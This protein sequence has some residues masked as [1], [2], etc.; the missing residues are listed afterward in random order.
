MQFCQWKPDKSD[1]CK[2]R[3]KT[4]TNDDISQQ[5]TYYRCLFAQLKLSSKS[6][7]RHFHLHDTDCPLHTQNRLHTYE[8]TFC[9]KSCLPAE[10]SPPFGHHRQKEGL[11][12]LIFSRRATNISKELFMKPYLFAEKRRE[13]EGLMGPEYSVRVSEQHQTPTDFCSKD[14]LS[15]GSIRIRLL[16]VFSLEESKSSAAAATTGTKTTT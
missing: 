14:F 16:C 9:W 8:G 2:G 4:L 11:F 6:S 5:P 10:C 15:H 3:A 13:R 1:V 12:S 7:C